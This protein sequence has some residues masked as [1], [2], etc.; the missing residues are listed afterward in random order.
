ML[1]SIDLA[2]VG[3]LYAAS[4]R[5]VVPAPTHTLDGGDLPDVVLVDGPA[6]IFHMPISLLLDRSGLLLE[7]LD[8][9]E[10]EEFLD[11]VRH[12]AGLS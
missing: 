3:H 7:H 5:D 11:R 12:D 4:G 10:H 1:M 2:T 8:D 6:A 9:E